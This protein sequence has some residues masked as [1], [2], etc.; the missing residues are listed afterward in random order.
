LEG[1]CQCG[2]IRYRVSGEPL[3]AAIRHCTMCRRANAAPAVAWARFQQAQVAILAGA[4]TIYAFSPGARRGF[5]AGCGTQISFTADYIPS[6]ADLT[7]GSLDQPER[8]APALHYWERLPWLHLTDD[9]PKH[10]E[11]PPVEWPGAARGT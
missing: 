9:L 7:V 10:P 2:A 6:L 5:C 3:L 4:P 8:I 11:S 1:G